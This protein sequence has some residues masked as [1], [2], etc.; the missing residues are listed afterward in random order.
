M[1]LTKLCRGHCKQRKS[2]DEFYAERRNADGK[3]HD[4]KVCYC[5]T[6]RKRRRDRRGELP[7]RCLGGCGREVYRLSR[8]TEC[9]YAYQREQE[10]RYRDGVNPKVC[11]Q[12]R[13]GGRCIEALIFGVNTFGYTTAYCP[14]H[15]ES[16]MPR[17]L[18][19]KGVLH[20]QRADLERVM[21]SAA[22]TAQ[23]PAD[24]KASKWSQ[25]RTARTIQKSGNFHVFGRDLLRR[26]HAA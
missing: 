4:C 15:G 11:G 21:R 17:T 8:C 14:V 12:L 22:K 7:K 10:S 3:R 1:P 13:H 25:G 18:P 24:K 26:I 20:T 9:K 5:A 23:R 2:I 6:R 19:P 16:V